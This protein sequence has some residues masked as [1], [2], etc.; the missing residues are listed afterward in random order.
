MYVPVTAVYVVSAPLWLPPVVM[1]VRSDDIGHWQRVLV[2]ALAT[3][4]PAAALVGA[5]LGNDYCTGE[6]GIGGQGFVGTLWPNCS[7]AHV[8]WLIMLAPATLLGLLAWVGA[9][10]GRQRRP[11]TARP[12]RPEPHF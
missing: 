1:V 5:F 4:S 12:N 11:T 3:L 7:N 10:I 9:I 2:I 6:I 8:A